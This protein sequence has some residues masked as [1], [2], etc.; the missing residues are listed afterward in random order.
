MDQLIHDAVQPNA[1]DQRAFPRLN[2]DVARAGF[3]GIE[4]DV[5]YK[6]ADFNPLLFG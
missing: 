1:D 4:Q 5:V 6:R 2:M 3:D